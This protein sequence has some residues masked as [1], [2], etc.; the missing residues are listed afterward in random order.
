[1]LND[2]EN[3]P[4]IG[5]QTAQKLREVGYGTID[6]IASANIDDLLELGISTA[7]AQKMVEAARDQF[8]VK[9]QTAADLLEQRK[10]IAKLT[11]SSKALDDLLDGGIESR[12]IT[13]TH[14]AYGSGK[15]VSKD[16]KVIYFNPDT[17][18]FES[19]EEIY[20]KYKELSGEKPFEE[21]YVV[22]VPQIQVVGFSGNKVAK[23][24]AKFIYKQKQDKLIEITTRR[25]RKLR[26][27]PT[28]RL[29]CFDGGIEWRPAA[30]LSKG[31]YI[32]SPLKMEL[33]ETSDLSTDD[34]YFLGIF[35]AEGTANPFSI[36]TGSAKIKN[37]L[38]KY[39]K[40][41][42]GFTPTIRVRQG[43]SGEIYLILLRIPCRELLGKLAKSNAAT[44]HV[45]HELFS[46]SEGVAASFIAGYLDCYPGYAFNFRN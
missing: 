6:A 44:K 25:G 19:M 11:T 4:G 36:T 3:L 42:F 5:E 30:A 16:T 33:S 18:H 9:F 26:I 43:K 27:T 34:G 1:M 45:P 41:R 28:H 10:D 12:S 29:V 39:L 23:T 15:C 46:C 37:W 7:K 14:G 24:S 35:A 8:D 38:D 17:P 22:E 32:A 20:E 13:E 21:G 2:I 31:M 40:S